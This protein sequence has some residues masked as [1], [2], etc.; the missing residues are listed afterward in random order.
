METQTKNGKSSKS[1]LRGTLVSLGA[2]ATGAALATPPDL[3]IN[4]ST[5]VNAFGAALKN[6]IT[7]NMGVLF[8]ILAMVIGFGFIWNHVRRMGRSL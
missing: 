2:L 4:Y 6:V 3:N 8:L 1:I 7:T 5:H